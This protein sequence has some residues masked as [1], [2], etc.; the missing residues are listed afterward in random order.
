[1]ESLGYVMLHFC[2]GSQPRQGLKDDTP[3][4]KYYSIMQEITSPTEV[5]CSGFPNEFAMYINYS[6]S[7]HFDDKPDYM[8]LRKMFMT[9]AAASSSDPPRSSTGP[10]TSVK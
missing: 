3:K 8:N 7:L 10:Y 5:R 4:Q 9:F 1:M 6:R 2:R